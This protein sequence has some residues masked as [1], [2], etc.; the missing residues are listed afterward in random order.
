MTSL[1]SSQD[2][3]KSA[4]EPYM[5]HR[6][7]RHLDDVGTGYGQNFA[8]FARFCSARASEQAFY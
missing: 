7:M 8:Y 4:L 2:L 5:P 6:N 1:V 3:T